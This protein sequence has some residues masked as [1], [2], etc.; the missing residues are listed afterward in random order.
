MALEKRSYSEL[1]TL[2]TYDARLQYLRCYGKVG[3]ETFG[4]NRY[5]N[6]AFYHSMEWARAKRLAIARDNGK[7]LGIPE[8][9]ILDRVIVHH[10]NPVTI[11]DLELGNPA[12]VDLE[13]LI[14]CSS[15][16]H[17]RI[18]YGEK[19]PEGYIPRSENDT[20]PWKR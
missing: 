14:C 19:K 20:C 2:P 12:V 18:H 16:T 6:Q 9:D 11:E 1:I 5:F 3:I 17:R 10:I 13:N 7:D 8:L 4:Q 15:L